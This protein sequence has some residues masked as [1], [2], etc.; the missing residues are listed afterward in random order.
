MINMKD[1]LSKLPLL[2]LVLWPL[3]ACVP[4]PPLTPP[5]ISQPAEDET[6]YQQAEN[7]YRRQAYRQALQQYTAYLERHPQGGHATAARL[8][9]AELL[10]LLGDWQGALRRYQTLLAREPAPEI[11]LKAR[12]GLGQSHFKLGRYQQAAQILDS[13]TAR[14][15][16]RSLWFSTQAL[17]AEIALKQ[18]Q[19][20]QAFTRLRLAAQDLPAGDQEW[21]DDLKTRL[22]EQAA[23][24]ELQSLAEMYR[25]TPLSAALLLRLARLAQEAGRLEEAK[26]WVNTLQERF[27]ASPEAATGARLLAGARRSL[28]V[29][30]PLTGEMGNV[31]QKVRQ[32]MELAVKGAAV[33]LTFR[34][35]RNDPGASAQAV[36]DLAQSP[37]LTAI[38]G[39]LTAGVAQAA[40]EAAQAARVPLIAL[41]QKSGLT[42]TGDMVFQAFITP[43]QQVWALLRYTLGNLGLKSYAVLYPDSSYGRTFLQQFQEELEAQGGELAAQESY[44]PGTHDFAPVLAVLKDAAAGAQA[45]FIPDDLA[46]AA[47]VA[48]SLASGPWKPARL[49][50]TNLMHQ[51]QISPA[52]A[53]ALEGVLFPDA[54][55][56]GDSN[57]GVQ[58]FVAAYRQQYGEDPDYLAAQGFVVARLLV[59]LLESEKTLD[60]SNL[61]HL[62]H[63]AKTYP[64]IPWFRG[65]SPS[66]EEEAHIY[67]LTIKD[68]KVQM[69]P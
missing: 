53:R 61:P 52:Q 58:Q 66:R 3:A 34:D 31:G 25:D 42:Q 18:G 37:G 49:L 2:V 1:L 8:R 43:R 65:F 59:K 9:E 40:A 26:K 20:A 5:P 14:D 19:V 15:L 41:S 30:L 39:P 22:V 51:P 4:L 63:T 44:A 50:G 69:A 33:E 67:V 13:L 11:A 46:V 12:Y 54:F 29:L 36:R 27:P 38:L 60:R 24:D 48:D 47:E 23:P 21:F 16:P 55:F 56:S 45:L 68:G 6:L 7:S 35:T 57:S 17:L 28:G 62:L 64:D 10:G 32:G